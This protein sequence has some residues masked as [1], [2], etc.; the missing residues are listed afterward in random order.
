MDFIVDIDVSVP[1]PARLYDFYLGGKDNYD[2]DR[3]YAEQVGKVFP[4]VRQAA[5]IN[6]AF[7]HRATECLACQGVRQFLDIGTGIP[8]APNL[9]QVAQRV[10]PRARVV[11][12][13][14]DPIVLAHARALMASTPEGRTT[15]VH[16]DLTRTEQIL[17]AAELKDVLWLGEPVAVSLNAV[18]HFVPDDQDPH[19][20]VATL[21]DAVVSGS[22]LVI[23]HATPDFDPDTFAEIERIYRNGGMACQFRTREQIGRFFTG[24]DLVDPGLVPPHRWRPGPLDLGHPGSDLTHLDAQVGLYAAIAK[25]P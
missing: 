8:T 11:Y 4:S 7:T 22:Y 2:A 20:I 9:H 14:N 10:D 24:M 25:K 21:L 18:L 3:E 23:T 6:R 16:A 1:H 5:H 19:D 17:D 12:V 15:Y 13:D